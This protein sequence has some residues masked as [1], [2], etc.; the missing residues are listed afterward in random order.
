LEIDLDAF[1]MDSESSFSLQK[2]VFSSALI[3]R[4]RPILH[5]GKAVNFDFFRL[6]LL[7]R[8]RQEGIIKIAFGWGQK[9]RRRKKKKEKS[10]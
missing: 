1:F 4:V 2:Q 5:N 10:V 6:F 7:D 9:A 3:S 8:H